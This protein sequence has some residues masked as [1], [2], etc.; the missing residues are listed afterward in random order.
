LQ[1]GAV[2]REESDAPANTV[3]A[4]SPEADTKV[5]RGSSVDVVIA[6]PVT[7]VAVPNLLNFEEAEAAQALENANLQ[8]GAVKEEVNPAP[9]GT[10][11]SQNPNAGEQVRLGSAVNVTISRQLVS[12][13]LVMMDHTAPKSG[14][15]LGFHAHLQPGRNGARYQFTFGDG[16]ISDWL[17]APNTTH[18]YKQAGN[19]RIQAEALIGND[20]ITSDAVTL[21]I[22]PSWAPW[23]PAALLLLGIPILAYG[24]YVAYGR[25]LFQKWVRVVP[26]SDLGKQQYS[27]Q[28][29]EVAGRDLSIRVVE[30]FGKQTVVRR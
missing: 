19:Y 29:D 21:A 25:T 5:G 23:M 30:D 9:S 6:E 26:R 28:E 15:P 11:L 3:T 2:A 1:M 12:E 13:L 8:M 22:V 17:A 16:Q 14:E 18:V 4:Q 7:T 20:R 27:A 24:G 10:V